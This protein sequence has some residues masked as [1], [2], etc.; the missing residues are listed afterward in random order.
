AYAAMGEL[1][2]EVD[3]L[4][5]TPN[6]TRRADIAYMSGEQMQSAPNGELSV[7]AFVAEVISKNDQINEVEEKLQ[8]YFDNGVQVVWVIFPKLKQ[9]KVYRSIRD[10]TVCF[11]DDVCSAAPELPDFQITVN[12]VF[13]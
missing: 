3:M 12:D 10:I 8:E 13:A 7:C 2:S 6:R 11:G 4:M 5:Q 1:M 9:V